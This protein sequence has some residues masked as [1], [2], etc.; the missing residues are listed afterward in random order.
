MREMH[1]KHASERHARECVCESVGAS[2]RAQRYTA[3]ALFS[4]SLVE[5]GRELVLKRSTQSVMKLLEL[6]VRLRL[7]RLECYPRV[8]QMIVQTPFD[9]HVLLLR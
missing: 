9:A 3:C 5:C 2:W 6:L 4:S 7:C 1:T 8:F